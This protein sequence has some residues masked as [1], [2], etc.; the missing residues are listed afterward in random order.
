MVHTVLDEQCLREIIDGFL[1]ETRTVPS[2]ALVRALA[3]CC[4]TTEA[5][6]RSVF[7]Q[8]ARAQGAE[9][10]LFDSMPFSGSG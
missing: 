1:A 8:R 2:D 3:A 10:S 4:G 9:T 6:V 7:E 5:A